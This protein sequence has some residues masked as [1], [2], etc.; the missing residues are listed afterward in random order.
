MATVPV[1]AELSERM[2]RRARGP[3]PWLPRLRTPGSPMGTWSGFTS[4]APGRRARSSSTWSAF[5]PGFTL[6][7]SGG[8]EGSVALN[9]IQPH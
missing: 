8:E 5:K 9:R 3:D 7:S 6:G 2:N 1:F 4:Q